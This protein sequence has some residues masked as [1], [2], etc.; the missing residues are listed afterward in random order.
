MFK[1]L[2]VVTALALALGI[3]A[4]SIDIGYPTAGLALVPG[5]NFTVEVD[6]PDTL[7]GSTEV[8]V[9]IGLRSC[10]TQPSCDAVSAQEDIGSILY[11]GPYNPVFTLDDPATRFKPP[12]QNFTVTVPPAEI[13]GLAVLSV[14]HLSLVGAGPFALLETKNITVN[15]TSA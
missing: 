13:S 7:T 10:G 12:H 4:Q 9:V 15:I 1:S 3:A 5:Q 11:N 6:R 8:A 2:S 14:T